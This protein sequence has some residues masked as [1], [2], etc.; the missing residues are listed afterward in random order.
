MASPPRA[1]S[2]SASSSRVARAAAERAAWAN[3]N[4]TGAWPESWDAQTKGLAKSRG[5][6]QPCV[7]HLGIV[8]QRASRG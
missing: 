6:D 8:E 2:G 5:F 1:T 4:R 7:N 3:K